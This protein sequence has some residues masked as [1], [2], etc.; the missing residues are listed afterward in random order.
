[1]RLNFQQAKTLFNQY[2]P[3]NTRKDATNILPIIYKAMCNHQ[4]GV[5]MAM[6]AGVNFL[7][8]FGY[9]KWHHEREFALNRIDRHFNPFVFKKHH[10][11]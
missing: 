2:I 7:Y 10:T 4:D 5:V 9:I 6:R 11:L 8:D 3:N 1:M